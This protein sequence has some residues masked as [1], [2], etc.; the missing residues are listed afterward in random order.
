MSISQRAASLLT[1]AWRFVRAAALEL[2]RALTQPDRRE[3]QA[4]DREESVFSPRE[5]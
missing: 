3:S 4:R 5:F 1:S 2:N